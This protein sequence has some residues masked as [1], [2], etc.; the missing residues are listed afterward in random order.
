MPYEMTGVVGLVGGLL[1]MQA[2]KFKGVVIS[3]KQML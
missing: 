2:Y 1:V 3:W